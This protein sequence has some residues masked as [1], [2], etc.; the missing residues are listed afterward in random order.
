MVT[1]AQF[2]KRGLPDAF[3]LIILE[4]DEK[5][6]P[7]DNEH[8]VSLEFADCRSVPSCCVKQYSS[9][10]SQ[11]DG[12]CSKLISKAFQAATVSLEE[13]VVARR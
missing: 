12:V 4:G 10:Q 6:Q 5:P 13:N 7:E 3:E 2:Q 11:K 1:S 9:S 8:F